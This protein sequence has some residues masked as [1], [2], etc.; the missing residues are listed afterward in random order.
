[1]PSLI[2]VTSLLF[3]VYFIFSVLGCFLFRDIDFLDKHGLIYNNLRNT[4]IL[5]PY[6][7]IGVQSYVGFSNFV[8]AFM[9]LYR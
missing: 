8:N 6:Q 4:V 2:N 7:V 9:T 5:Y 3:L 1:M